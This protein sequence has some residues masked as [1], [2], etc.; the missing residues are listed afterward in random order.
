MN[1]AEHGRPPA[2]GAEDRGEQVRDLASRWPRG[3]GGRVDAEALAARW[4]ASRAAA[5][6]AGLPAWARAPLSPALASAL[7]EARRARRLVRGLEPA[8]AQLEREA[9]GRRRAGGETGSGA[10]GRIARLLVVS[11]D[12][13]ERLLRKVERLHAI[14]EDVLEVLVVLAD[15]WQLGGALFGTGE[16][17]RVVLIDHKDA[18]ARLLAAVDPVESGSP[19]PA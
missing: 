18:V 16:R 6:A 7:F 8:T 13:S 3:L 15:E 9:A 14:H 5:Q 11:E 2:R 4:V 1:D 12:S 17:A 10:A 19:G